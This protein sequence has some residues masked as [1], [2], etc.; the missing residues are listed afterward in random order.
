[1]LEIKFN[2]YIFAFTVFFLDFEFLSGEN[3]RLAV[4][5]LLISVKSFFSKMW[6]ASYLFI[7]VQFFLKTKN[8]SVQEWRKCRREESVVDPKIF[9][10]RFVWMNSLSKERDRW[11]KNVTAIKSFIDYMASG[12]WPIDKGANKIQ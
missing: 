5:K 9:K 2:A 1:M 4:A 7:L 6:L 8:G 10:C 12:Q 11:M 3:V